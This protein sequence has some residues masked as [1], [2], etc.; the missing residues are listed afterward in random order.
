MPRNSGALLVLALQMGLAV[1]IDLDVQRH[2]V[3]A[4]RA[5]FDVVLVRPGRDVHRNDDLLAARVAGIHGL[6]MGRVSLPAAFLPGLLFH[7]AGGRVVKRG[8]E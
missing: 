3:A 7:G 2:G 4:D 5:V 6:L 8:Y 1:W